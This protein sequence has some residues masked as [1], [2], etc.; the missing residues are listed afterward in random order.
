MLKGV[1]PIDKARDFAKRFGDANSVVHGDRQKA[2]SEELGGVTDQDMQ[3]MIN[4]LFKMNKSTPVFGEYIVRKE[5]ESSIDFTRRI[6]LMVK[7]SIDAGFPPLLS[8]KSVKASKSKDGEY[9]WNA[10]YQH[11][12]CITEIQSAG[13]EALLIKL[14][15]SYSGKM[16]TGFLYTADPR[17]SVVPMKYKTD[18][19][20]NDIWNWENGINCMFLS[21][22]KLPLGTQQANWNERTYIAARFL[23]MK[24]ADIHRL[25]LPAKKKVEAK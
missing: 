12:V 2:Y 9:L 5:K 25:S 20:G 19:D 8:V 18:A 13:D 22:P 10:I 11:W 14:A 4:R 16:I 17:G 3:A 23:I 6:K 1:A 21:A 7:E 15:D 24:Q